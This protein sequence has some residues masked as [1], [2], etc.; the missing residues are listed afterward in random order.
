MSRGRPGS[1]RG[2]WKSEDGWIVQ[3]R[4]GRDKGAGA[5]RVGG[6]PKRASRQGVRL[7]RAFTPGLWKI[8]GRGRGEARQRGTLALNRDEWKELWKSWRVLPR[9]KSAASVEKPQAFENNR[10][11]LC[12]TRC[13]AK[14]AKRRRIGGSGPPVRSFSTEVSAVPVESFDRR[15][16]TVFAWCAFIAGSSPRHPR[17][18]SSRSCDCPCSE[19]DRPAR[20]P[21]S[22]PRRRAG[23][24]CGRA[25]FGPRSPGSRE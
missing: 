18:P 7:H 11:A 23:R 8:L 2:R 20:G 16:G 13:C 15:L 21:A 22:P 5:N 12:C 6:E 25:A 9:K 17:S 24:G 19:P 14:R 4:A 3:R 1:G 10:L